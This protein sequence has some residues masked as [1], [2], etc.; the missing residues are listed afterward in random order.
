MTP[1]QLDSAVAHL[2]E[3]AL[4]ARDWVRLAQ[5]DAEAE[6]R[7]EVQLIDILDEMTEIE[8]C[9]LMNR[10]LMN[11]KNAAHDVHEILSGALDRAVTKQAAALLKKRADEA[12]VGEFH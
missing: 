10:L 9:M 6:I 3:Q 8:E 12:R 7:E 1:A 4:D 2:D 11:R 5:D